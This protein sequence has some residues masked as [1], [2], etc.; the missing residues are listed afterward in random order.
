MDSRYILYVRNGC[1]FCTKAAQ[2]LKGKNKEFSTLDLKK[3][4][5]VLNELKDIYRWTTVPMIFEVVND[6]TYRLVGGYTDLV[7]SLES[8]N[9]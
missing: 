1:P 6:K 8:E 9:N 3:R 7:Q 5:K 4:P 2:L